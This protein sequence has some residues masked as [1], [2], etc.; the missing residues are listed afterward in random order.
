MS[1]S[2][3]AEGEPRRGPRHTLLLGGTLAVLLIVAGV[4]ALLGQGSPSESLSTN[5]LGPPNALVG[6]RL[7]ALPV[8]RMVN[9]AVADR[10]PWRDARGAVLLFF[11]EWCA[12][13]HS[14]GPRLAANPGRGEIGGV[15]I[16]GLDGDAALG[17]ARSF[18]ASDHVR[19]PVQ[20]DTGLQVAD[21]L[22]PSGFP[23]AVFVSRAGRVVAVHYGALSLMQLSAGL[24]EIVHP[25]PARS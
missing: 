12:V 23:A 18:V 8:M 17:A 11:A 6:E 21:R 9:A 25:M 14:E 7:P 2:A 20:W 22:L 5:P 10:T 13:C 24:S 4:L 16:V 3:P 19:F 15:R 1:S